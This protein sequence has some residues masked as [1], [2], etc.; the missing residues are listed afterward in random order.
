MIINAIAIANGGGGS[1]KPPVLE[2]L[3][4]TSN[5][6][7][8]PN[9]GVDGFNPV[10]VNVQPPLQTKAIEITANGQSTIEADSE[11]YG[12]ES[13]GLN[14]NVQPNLQTKSSSTTITSNGTSTI[15]LQPDSNYDGLSSASVT[16]T[17][18]VESSGGGKYVVPNGMKFAY[19][20][21]IP[22]DSLDFSQVTDA[23]RMFMGV[24]MYQIPYQSLE[25][26]DT[27]NITT[28][29]EMLK[30][31]FTTAWGEDQQHLDLSGWDTSKVTDMDYMLGDCGVLKSLDLSSWNTSAVTTITGMFSSC[32]DLTSLYGIENFD[33]SKV[34]KMNS[35]F[36]GC[37]KLTSLD[38]S[39][40]NTS[41]VIDTSYMFSYNIALTSINLSNWDTSKVTNVY[42][43]FGTSF[44]N[45]SKLT[46][47]DMT[48][49]ILP[50]INL[51]EWGLNYCNALTVDS[52]VS[53]LNALQQ[54]DEGTSYTCTIGS[55]NL[56]KLSD[57]QKA[58]ATNKGWTLN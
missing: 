23:E 17:T 39:N 24:S 51:T 55:D 33:T 57:T 6:V 26:F 4:A 47:L 21:D 46:N 45:L 13:V 14:V 7:Y 12:L 36:S 2:E 31:A 27:S 9:T 43:M 19:S 49:A 10:N 11:Y 8:T 41:S 52:L 53:V 22:F 54:L 3:N 34:T 30:G 32:D 29:R 40:W 5:G 16:I 50:K 42:S 56:A 20:E 58:I 15:T 38:L 37:R 25:K 18:N 28:M 48:N 1:S 35:T 44:S